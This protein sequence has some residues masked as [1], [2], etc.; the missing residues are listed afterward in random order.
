M[1]SSFNDKLQNTFLLQGE[2][3]EQNEAPIGWRALKTRI[4]LLKGKL[5]TIF[6]IRMS[7]LFVNEPMKS[8][9]FPK[10]KVI[11]KTVYFLFMHQWDQL[12]TWA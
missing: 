9:T 11:L 8:R 4:L 12:E 3:C 10:F 1:I 5:E 6:L 2:T 7:S